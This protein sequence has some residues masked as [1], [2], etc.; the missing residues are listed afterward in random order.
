[1]KK[2]VISLF[3]VFCLCLGFAP[4]IGAEESGSWSYPTSAPT[5]SWT[6]SGTEADPY[7]IT[8]A[9][10]LADLAYLVNNKSKDGDTLYSTLHYKLGADIDLGGKEW[11]P[12]GT[13]LSQSFKGVFDGAGYDGAR[14]EISRL[15]I[16]QY[17]SGYA[18]LF[19]YASNATIKNI[20]LL[21]SEIKASGSGA[22]GIVGYVLKSSIIS[23][24][25]SSAVT[26]AASGNAGGIVG[27]IGN[28]TTPSTIKN[29]I[30]NGNITGGSSS[31]GICGN[32]INSIIEEC[33]NTGAI[34]SSSSDG[35][36]G[37]IAGYSD[38]GTPLI[39]NCYNTGGISGNFNSHSGGILGELAKGTV[40]NCHSYGTVTGKTPNAIVGY[41]GTSNSIQNCFALD[42]L[43]NSGEYARTAEQFANGTVCNAL[44]DN[45]DPDIW[46]QGALYP[47]FI[48]ES[49][50]EDPT[51]KPDDSDDPIE[52]PAPVIPVT[53]ITLSETVLSLVVSETAELT[54][55]IT[56]ENA[57]KQDI[58][59]T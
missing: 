44:N 50:T 43:A 1:M 57:T 21:D 16:S 41:Y 32:L 9:Q 40:V 27:C 7:V 19:G 20:T 13:T 3:L 2:R 56:P 49:D 4:P 51:E 55:S 22:A 5:L 25:N 38:T 15:K 33:Y 14:Y 36:V 45:C 59:W 46:V 29:C 18:G 28:S 31:G 10:Q 39:K 8:T 6:G 35:K 12:I 26:L 11:T 23:C 48:S 47:V 42:T 37:G 30:N 58:T 17:A 34:Q 53:G 54:A 52:E 24:A